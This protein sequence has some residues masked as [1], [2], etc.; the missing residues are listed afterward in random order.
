MSRQVYI[1]GKFFPQEEAK[2]SVFDHGLLYGDGVFEGLR[3]YR[4][5]VFRLREHI[6]RL[7]ESAKAIWLE[8]PHLARCHVRRGQRG[9]PT[10]QNRRRLRATGGDARGRHAGARSQSLQQSAGDHHRGYDLAVPQGALRKGAGD[11]HGE[12]AAHASGGA[13]PADQV[14]QLP[15]QHPGQ[16][17]R[18]AGRLHRSADAQPQRRSRRVHGRQHLPGPR[19]RCCTRRRSTRAFWPASRGTP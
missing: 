14:A 9:G 5:K 4:G 15:Q 16:D 18:P 6:A 2:I 11:R 8:I 17:R 7:Y 19:R 10:Q 3:A 12:R 13:Q 1:N